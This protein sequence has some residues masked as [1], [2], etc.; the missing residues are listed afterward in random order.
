M[1]NLDK[2][3]KEKVKVGQLEVLYTEEDQGVH[4]SKEI[5]WVKE[6]LEKGAVSSILE[7][8]GSEQK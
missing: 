8:R 1:A 2:Q 7:G 6:K 5:V 4:V 3:K